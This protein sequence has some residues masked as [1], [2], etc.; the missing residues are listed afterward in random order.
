MTGI[1]TAIVTWLS[2]SKIPENEPKVL[3][4]NS[5][6]SVSVMEEWNTT[7]EIDEIELNVKDIHLYD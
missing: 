5:G 7:H 1:T 6:F 2:K 3:V 4:P